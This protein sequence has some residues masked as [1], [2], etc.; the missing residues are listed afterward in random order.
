MATGSD[1]VS[2]NG[3][4]SSASLLSSHRLNRA[5]TSSSCCDKLRLRNLSVTVA[6]TPSFFGGPTPRLITYDP[7]KVPYVE[8]TLPGKHRG[9]QTDRWL[10]AQSIACCAVALG[11]NQFTPTETQDAL[12]DQRR[13]VERIA[14]S[15]AALVAF[16]IGGFVSHVVAVWKER[17]TNYSGLIGSM[18][19]LL[20]AIS[21]C[22][23]VSPGP[24][25]AGN[26]RDPAA[27]EAL[28][29]KCRATLGRYILLA[30][31][32]AILKPR[33]H[34]DT[35]HGRAHLQTLALLAAG[36]WEAMVPGDRHTSVLC[37]VQALCVDLKRRGLLDQTE[38]KIVTEAVGAARA[39]ANDLMS[40][41][42]RDL[43][44]PYANQV[45]W[46]VRLAVVL[47]TILTGLDMRET[48]DL[49]C[50]VYATI[51]VFLYSFFF[52]SFIGMHRVLHNPFLDRLIDIGHEPIANEGLRSLADGLMRG[53]SFLPPNW[54]PARAADA[55]MPH[56]A[57][58]E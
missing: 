57:I 10:W 3:G 9:W 30:S 1:A 50:K 2:I 36:E 55:A 43:P 54:P 45:A 27:G 26:G 6:S 39:Q 17:R 53:A 25:N 20:L 44:M 37:W 33:G 4:T 41:T 47:Q 46:L 28:I 22:V 13:V 15:M 11:I 7:M 19:N 35:E 32:L 40:S 14:S 12:E 48:A 51:G 29:R 42:S 34:I 5:T 58:P 56:A 18:R 38:L 24:W 31:E 49:S 8:V 21:S 52:S 23:S 16:L